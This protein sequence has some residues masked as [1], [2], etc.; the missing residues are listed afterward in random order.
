MAISL[1]DLD[2][3]YGVSALACGSGMVTRWLDR[4]SVLSSQPVLI[5]N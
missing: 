4:D 2:S 1:N 5:S 3:G